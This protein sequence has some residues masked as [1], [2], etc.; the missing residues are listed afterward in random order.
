[1]PKPKRKS[2]LTGWL[3]PPQLHEPVTVTSA[4]PRDRQPRVAKTIQ[5]TLYLPPAVHDQLR[6]LAFHRRVKMHTI[7]MQGLDKIFQ[8]NG[9]K[10]ISD[11]KTPK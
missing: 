6:S 9:L 5:Q 1:M 4:P 10:S 3:E 11:L 2:V 8:E 7:I